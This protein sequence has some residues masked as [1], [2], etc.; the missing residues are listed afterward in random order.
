MD[1][2]L[3]STPPSFAS[4]AEAVRNLPRMRQ[5]RRPR[6]HFARV[7]ETTSPGFESL[8]ETWERETR[9]SSDITAITSHW[10]YRAIIG[11][12]PPVVPR[13]LDR[14]RTH[15]GFWFPALEEIAEWDPILREDWGDTR[16]MARAWFE[17]SK[18][19]DA[20]SYRNQRPGRFL[21]VFSETA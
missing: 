21:Q 10:A 3:A 5:L 9:N 1:Y 6:R 18:R 14:M 7:S 8:A 19:P 16:K 17:W 11:M 13:I 4:E 2:A 15:G 20:K 12:G